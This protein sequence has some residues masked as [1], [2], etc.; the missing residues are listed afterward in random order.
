MSTILSSSLGEHLALK[1][2]GLKAI[3]GG[4]DALAHARIRF[5]DESTVSFRGEANAS[6]VILASV[7]AMVKGANRALN[8][9]RRR[10]QSAQEKK[11]T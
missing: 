11:A 7:H 10:S 5:E 2:F 3:T 6:D 8:H 4:T 1:E 9:Q